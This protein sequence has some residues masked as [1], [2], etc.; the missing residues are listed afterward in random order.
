MAAA[1]VFASRW[2]VPAA[3]MRC[4]TLLERM[5]LTA[6]TSWWPGVRIDAAPDRLAPGVR[7]RM[8]VRSPL[9][10]RLRTA[11][12]VD[13]VIP[14]RSISAASM[15]DLRGRGRV[16]IHATT[17]GSVIIVRWEVATERGWMNATA[18]ALRPAFVGAHR[19]VMAAG[20]RGIR[21][22]LAAGDREPDH[23]A[24]SSDPGFPADS[25]DGTTTPQP[26]RVP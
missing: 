16:D 18:F 26:G 23:P 9:G 14:G 10:Y 13:D 22:A 1:Y 4:W 17:T 8:S 5:L 24:E 25:L 2:E 15:G 21:A 3:P 6:D 12:V 7:L 19:R 11:L 20:E